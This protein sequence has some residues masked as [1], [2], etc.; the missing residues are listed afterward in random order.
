[1]KQVLIEINITRILI[2]T[3][4]KS[5]HT[6]VRLFETFVW[7]CQRV[8]ETINYRATVAGLVGK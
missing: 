6:S 4:L 5:H 7:L 3:S 1:M 2:V 8:L